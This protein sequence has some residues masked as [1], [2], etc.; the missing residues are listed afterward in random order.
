MFKVTEQVIHNPRGHMS[1]EGIKNVTCE[2]NY[3]DNILSCSHYG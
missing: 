2:M 1:V 3:T